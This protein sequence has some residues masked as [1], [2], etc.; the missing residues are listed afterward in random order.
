A[1]VRVTNRE[2]RYHRRR[3]QP[4]RREVQRRASGEAAILRRPGRDRESRRRRVSD[5]AGVGA[6][7]DFGSEGARWRRNEIGFAARR[8]SD[9]QRATGADHGAEQQ[10]SSGRRSHA[11]GWVGGA[12]DGRSSVGPGKHGGIARQCRARRSGGA[13]A[14]RAAGTG[15]S[16]SLRGTNEGVE[17]A[18]S[19]LAQRQLFAH[20]E[21]DGPSLRAWKGKLRVLW[22]VV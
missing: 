5:G 20:R 19:P 1:A 11:P 10:G 21:R 2:L 3:S 9:W 4:R 15:E 6:V 13:R 7:Q 22:K 16:R 8:D 17:G 12:G 14:G 18:L